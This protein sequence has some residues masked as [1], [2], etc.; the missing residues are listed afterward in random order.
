MKDRGAIP[1]MRQQWRNTIAAYC[2]P[3]RDRP[4]DRI[5]TQAVLGVLKPIW[6]KI[7]DTASR[8]RGRIETI[9]NAAQSA[10][11]TTTRT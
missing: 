3:L 7:P 5:D 1:S 8:V 10:D 2:E 6:T 9:L 11:A 4:V